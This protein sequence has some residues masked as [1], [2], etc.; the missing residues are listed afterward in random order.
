MKINLN[1]VIKTK[2][3]MTRQGYGL[4]DLFITALLIGAL[5]QLI[6]TFII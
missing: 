3:K 6:I 1:K 2:P 5:I 4:S